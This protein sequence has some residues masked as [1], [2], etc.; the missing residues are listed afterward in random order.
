MP[1]KFLDRPAALVFSLLALQLAPLHN[2]D[3]RFRGAVQK[4]IPTV[5]S[6]GGLQSTLT[7]M[8][9]STLYCT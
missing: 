8:E 7:G 1:R 3:A 2:V 6:D 5:G 9:D 4:P